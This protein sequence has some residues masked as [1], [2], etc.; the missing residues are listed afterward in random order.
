MY[1]I[2]F[3]IQISKIENIG[4]LGELRVLNLARNQITEV[5]NLNGLDSLTELN[6]RHNNIS[7]VVRGICIYKLYTAFSTLVFYVLMVSVGAMIG[8]IDRNYQLA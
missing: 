3:F 5:E 4:H 1:D 6:L 8:W 7:L 2:L